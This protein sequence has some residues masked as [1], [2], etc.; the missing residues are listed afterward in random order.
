MPP[1]G[2]GAGE[3]KWVLPETFFDQLPEVMQQVPAPG[4][5]GVAFQ[6][7]FSS[8][9][10]TRSTGTMTW[11]S[12][13]WM[14]SLARQCTAP[15]AR[16]SGWKYLGAIEVC[17]SSILLLDVAGLRETCAAA[18]V[19]AGRRPDEFKNEPLFNAIAEPAG[20]PAPVGVRQ[21]SQCV[22]RF[23]RRL[24]GRDE[25]RQPVGHAVDLLVR[26]AA[27]KAEADRAHANLRGHP[28]GPEDG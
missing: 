8:S 6:P 27:P 5:V 17:K 12:S 20:A 21:S 25:G 16:P 13:G 14:A 15:T 7:W 1:A 24:G 18:H 22:R 9:R 4:K 10:R 2:Q 3:T 23:L 19:E 28:H 26:S 11:L